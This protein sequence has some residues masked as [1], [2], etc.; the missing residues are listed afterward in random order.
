MRSGNAALLPETEM[1]TRKYIFPDGVERVFHDVAAAT[2]L[3]E[4]VDQCGYQRAFIVCSRTLQ[5]ETEVVDRIRSAL[6]ARVVGMTS[7]IG[8]HSPIGNVLKGAAQV[9]DANADVLVTI[10]GGSVLDFGKFVQLCVSEGAYTKE[11]LLKFH[12]ATSAEG[13]ASTA[14]PGLRQIAI[15][16]TLSTAEWTPAGTPVDEETRKKA[17]FFVPRGAPQVIIYDPDIASRT[18]SRLLLS[19]GIRG[20]DH[21]INTLCAEA[22]NPFTS[23]MA[24]KAIALFIEN[25]P[26][27]ALDTSDR[28]ALCNCQLATWY[29]GMGQMTISMMHGFSHFIVHVVGP[30]ASI[31]H[32]DTA[33]VMMLAQ[34]RWL[35]E[36]GGGHHDSIKRMLGRE[37]DSFAAI[38]YGLLK[39][40]GLPTTLSELGL[41]DS[42]VEAIIP[43]ALAHPLLTRHNIR[44]ISSADDLRAILALVR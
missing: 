30:Y 23:H 38:L 36:L 20:L 3:P 21:A 25:L 28:E 41:D 39:E 43:R 4:I 6:G 37:G 15:P 14:P 27:L 22:P 29:T 31:G 44:P 7:E 42:D 9:R 24:E 16:T 8:E 34:A 2:V 18:P 26:R 17:T 19:T 12:R 10:G 1:L 5:R 11:A 32:S 33:C 13:R 40:L 35:E